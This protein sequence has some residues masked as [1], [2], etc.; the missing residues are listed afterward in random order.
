MK[1]ILVCFEALCGLWLICL[2]TSIILDPSP[3][4]GPARKAPFV[5]AELFL[6]V[7]CFGLAIADW[8]KL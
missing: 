7:V 4:M 8:I 2:A 3:V 1:K 5:A 6:S